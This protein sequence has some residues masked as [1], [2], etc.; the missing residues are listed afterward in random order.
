MTVCVQ[1]HPAII[2]ELDLVHEDDQHTH[3][4]SLLEGDF[5]T[6]DKLSESRE[7]CVWACSVVV[8]CVI[9]FWCVFA[10]VFRPDP[11]YLENEEAYKS[12]REEVLGEESDESGSE[13]DEEESEESEEESEGGMHRICLVYWVVFRLELCLW[14]ILDEANKLEISDQTGTSEL[15][16]RRQIYLTIMS[17]LDFEECAHKLLKT[18]KEG[19]EV[20]KRLQEYW[21]EREGNLCGILSL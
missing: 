16:L 4:V 10:D 3:F 2:A 7:W 5:D 18:M 14:C 19:Q 17:S 9:F 8:L 20:R 15:V 12:I 13:E 1:D 21:G 11:N 6:E